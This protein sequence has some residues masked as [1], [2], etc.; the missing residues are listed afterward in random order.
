MTRES[1]CKD[2]VNTLKILEDINGLP[3]A[4]PDNA[5]P[6]KASP[7]LSLDADMS[8][9]DYLDGRG[10][11]TEEVRDLVRGVICHEMAV[12]MSLCGIQELAR[13]SDCWVCGTD[14]YR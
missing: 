4:Y 14:N 13:W 6:A 7:V 1:E 10:D 8:L 11:V 2:V 3:Y 5:H 9:K 12:S